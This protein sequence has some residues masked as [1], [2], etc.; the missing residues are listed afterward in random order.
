[1][2]GWMDGWQHRP[3][4]TECREENLPYLVR[5]ALQRQAGV[6]MGTFHGDAGRRVVVHGGG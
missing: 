6:A 2:D 5:L 1:M 3:Y 4:N